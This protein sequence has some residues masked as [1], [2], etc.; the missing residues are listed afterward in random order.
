MMG[1]REIK[2]NK[3][4]KIKVNK[5]R[6]ILEKLISIYQHSFLDKMQLRTRLWL[7]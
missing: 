2:I 1:R 7:I 6:M 4:N 5:A 3:M